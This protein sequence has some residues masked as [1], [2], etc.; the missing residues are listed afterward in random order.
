MP[1]KRPTG[2]NEKNRSSAPP[3]ST[4][5]DRSS[6][7]GERSSQ[8]SQRPSTSQRPSSSQAPA[9]TQRQMSSQTQA[10]KAAAGIDRAEL[11]RKVNDLVQYLLIM[12]QK[13]YPIKKLDINKN[14]LK[15]HRSAFAHIMKKAQEK[16]GRVFGVD[17]VELQDKYKGS[18]ILLNRLENDTDNPHLL[19]PEEDNTKTGLLMVI[20]SLIYMNGNV[21]QDSELWHSLKKLG[22]EPDLPHPTFGDAKKLI[23]QEFVRQGYI[24]YIRQ[25]NVDPPSFEFKWG[26]RAQLET[27]KKHCLT[28]V[29]QIYDMDAERWTSQ[30]QDM[31]ETEGPLE[32][33]N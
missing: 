16:L 21:M 13:N 2:K 25:Q 19:W 12:W 10:D 33:G 11:D 5:N 3:P 15:E 14:V 29:S 24:E 27:S 7:R 4:R 26:Q 31:V 8:S 6:A 20:L 17:V 30:F 28:F 32:N 9:S 22:V 18:F 23:T 1:P